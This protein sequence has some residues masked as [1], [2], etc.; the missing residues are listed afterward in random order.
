MWASRI[1]GPQILVPFFIAVPAV[2]HT[3]AI[4]GFEGARRL[5]FMQWIALSEKDSTAE[6]LENRL[7]AAA[8]Q[9][10]ANSGLKAQEYSAPVL[11]LMFLCFAEG[12][13]CRPA[14]QTG[15]SWRKKQPRAQ[16]APWHSR[17]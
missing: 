6:T 9:F 1:R 11:G 7:W 4:I 8:D 15:K 17:G 12:P 14:H 10:R 16:P 3:I 13:L 2:C 5:N